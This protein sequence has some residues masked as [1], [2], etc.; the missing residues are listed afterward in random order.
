MGYD[1]SGQPDLI[2]YSWGW[3]ELHHGETVKFTLVISFFVLNLRK[4]RFDQTY[5]LGETAEKVEYIIRQ[6]MM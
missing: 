6:F 3:V 4:K 2:Y 1:G 5:N